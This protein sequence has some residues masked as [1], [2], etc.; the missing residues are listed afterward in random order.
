MQDIAETLMEQHLFVRRLNHT[1]IDMYQCGTQDCEPGHDYGPA[2]RDHFLIHYIT[3]GKGIFQV[4]GKTYNLT[5]NQ[6]FLIFPEIVTYYRADFE[7]PWKYSWVGFHGLKAGLYLKHAGLTMEN[8]VFTYDRDD[9]VK[10]C[11]ENMIAA[12]DMSAGR[13]IRLL[14]ILYLFLSRLIEVCGSGRFDNGGTGSKEMYAKKVIEFIEMNYSR[15]ITVS[16]IAR[17]VGLDR[18]YLGSVFKERLN[19]S[20]REYLMNFRINKACELMKNNSLSIGDISRS[21]GYDDPLLFSKIFR[22]AKGM[23]PREFRKLHNHIT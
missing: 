19:V 5:K 11:F 8:P 14:G 1:D 17:F 18:S 15:K 2:V 13:E 4:G 10:D 16:E 3:D 6:G 21:V 12:K 22:K 20:I 9:F 23:C 7:E